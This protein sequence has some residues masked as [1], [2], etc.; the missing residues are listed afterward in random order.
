MATRLQT[1]LIF[2]LLLSPESATAH[3]LDEFLQATFIEVGTNQISLSLSLTP[4]VDVAQQ[5]IPLID[6]NHDGSLSPQEIAV[7]SERVRTGLSLTVDSRS[8]S[9]VL[10]GSK[11]PDVTEMKEG[12]GV[13]SLQFT[14]L[15]TNFSAGTHR[16]RFANGHQTNISVYLANALVPGSKSITI[17]RQIRD[18]RQTTLEF[19]FTVAPGAEAARLS[20]NSSALWSRPSKPKLN[21]AGPPSNVSPSP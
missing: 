18:F 3:R 9:L 1:I 13:I 11:F 10:A 21:S 6:G 14:A 12:V 5:L 20:T 4:G 19:E 15:T 17:G 2:G 7:Y 16:L 8:Q